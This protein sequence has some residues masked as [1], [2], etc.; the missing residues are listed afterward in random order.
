MTTRIEHDLDLS[1]LSTWVTER[2]PNA[3]FA[4]ISGAHLYGFPSVDSDVDVRGCFLAPLTDLVGLLRPSET[5]DPKGEVECR[6]VEAVFHEVGKYFR[7]MLKHNGYVLEQVFS[8]II[9]RGSDFLARLRPLAAK[10]VTKNCYHH[11]RG[12]LQTQRKLIAKEEAVKAKSLLYAFRVVLT[13]IHLLRT[14]EVQSH[15]PTPAG[16]LGAKGLDELIE[17]KKAA[18][19]GAFPDIDRDAYLADLDGWERR[20]DLAFEESTLPELGPLNELHRFLIEL[21]MG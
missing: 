20:L 6:E 7:L 18:E 14:G 1:A 19:F 9:V 4:T 11:Y 3:L 12:F 5:V 21:R 2:T 16:L 13:G 8:P 17:R 10:C 15:L